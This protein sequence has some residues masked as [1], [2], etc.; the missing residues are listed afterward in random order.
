MSNNN[1][2]EG[3]NLF[4]AMNIYRIILYIVSGIISWKISHPKG[5]WS[6]ILFLILW[7]AIGWIIHQIVFLLFVFFNKELT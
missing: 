5:F 3:E 4:F 6:I 7:G 1:S 2:Q